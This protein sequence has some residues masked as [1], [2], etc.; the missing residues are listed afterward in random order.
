MRLPLQASPV[1]RRPSRARAGSGATLSLAKTCGA[2]TEL[3]WPNG[4][5]TGTCV[6]DCCRRVPKRVNGQTTWQTICQFESCS[7]GFG[8]FGGWLDVLFF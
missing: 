6:Q 1:L 4:T 3:K 5:G 2:C 8:G 7:C